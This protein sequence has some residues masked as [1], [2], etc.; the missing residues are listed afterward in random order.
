MKTAL[1]VG[2]SGGIGTALVKQFI[3]RPDFGRVLAAARCPIEYSSAKVESLNVDLQK[4]GTI[5]ALA[6]HCRRHGPLH[7]IVIASGILHG[8]S[9]GPEKSWLELSLPMMQA[10]FAINTFGPALVAKHC[11]PLLDRSN[12]SVFA[13]ISA[14]VGSIQDNRLGGWYS[15]RASKAALNMLVK[16]LAIELRRKNR[17]ASCIAL[18]PGTVNTRLSAPFQHRVPPKQ[19]FSVTDSATKLMQVMDQVSPE[20]SGKVFA[21]DGQEIVP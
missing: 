12:P 4:E 19:L 6:R 16:T 2:A 8:E 10:V 13:A 21:W 15:Y 7:R 17:T 14:R 1:V 20:Q 5:E 11:L 9:F 3:E 18:H